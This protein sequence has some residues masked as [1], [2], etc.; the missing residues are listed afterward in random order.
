MKHLLPKAICT[1]AIGLALNS[2]AYGE[3]TRYMM[4]DSYRN[5]PAEQ[6]I[7]TVNNWEGAE[8]YILRHLRY[9]SDR[10]NYGAE[11]FDAPFDEINARGR[12]DCDGGATAGAALLS[13]NARYTLSRM[14]LSGRGGAIGSF[15][16]TFGLSEGHDVTLVYDKE[17]GKYGSLGINAFDNIKP[18]YN[19]PE[20][21]F[22]RLNMSFLWI[23]DN[24]TLIE[25][26][27]S[28]LL[29]GKN[30]FEQ[31]NNWIKEEKTNGHS[32]NF[33]M[34]IEK[35]YSPGEWVVFEG[36]LPKE[37]NG[38]ETDWKPFM[39]SLQGR[40][41]SDTERYISEM[42]DRRNDEMTTVFVDREAFENKRK[43]QVSFKQ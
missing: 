26:D 30:G 36:E 14:H 27:T 34:A 41:N 22:K 31:Y 29:H 33:Y 11:D 24:F 20:D 5:V 1:A 2:G 3:A 10:A 15:L 4:R 19:T 8:D 32:R 9:S 6:A 17:T 38:D 21:I 16:G 42:S 35:P 28:S 43:P 39:E 25:Y 12:D 7:K 37:F 18:T 13:D 40:T 23:F